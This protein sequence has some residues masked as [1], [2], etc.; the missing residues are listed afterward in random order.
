M[1]LS[2]VKQNHNHNHS[3][4][5]SCFGY[6]GQDRVGGLLASTDF[7]WRE[8]SEDLLSC[9]PASLL[10]PRLCHNTTFNFSFI[11]CKLQ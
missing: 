9:V 1:S 6:E 4:V 11:D 10:F 8:K 2:R 7:P 5:R 3:H